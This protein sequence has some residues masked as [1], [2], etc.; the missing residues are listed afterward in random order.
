MKDNIILE[1]SFQ[2]SIKIVKLYKFLNEGKREF[3]LSRQ[4]LRAG[5]SI[6]ANVEE[7]VGAS[8]KRDFKYKL[9]IAYRE[10]R[11]THYWIRLLRETT[12]I[13]KESANPLLADCEELLRIL[14]AIQNTLKTNN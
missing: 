1:K 13:E 6:G 14:G 2:F 8:S 12:I 7:A 4:L 3:D 10:A 9:D 5:T 11:E